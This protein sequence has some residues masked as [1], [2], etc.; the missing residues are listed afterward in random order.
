MDLSLRSI[1]ANNWSS[2]NLKTLH[3]NEFLS[4]RYVHLTPVGG[5]SFWQ[6]SVD[7]NIDVH[8]DV[9]YQV[10]KLLMPWTP[11]IPDKSSWEGCTT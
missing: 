6:L 1:K 2:D 11:T 5:Y 10:H 8:K 9:H 3:F 4:P 7:H